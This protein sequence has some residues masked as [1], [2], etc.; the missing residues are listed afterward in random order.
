VDSNRVQFVRVRHTSLLE[1]L[2]CIKKRGSK[3]AY[4][5]DGVRTSEKKGATKQRRWPRFGKNKSE[6]DAVWIMKIFWMSIALVYSASM[7]VICIDWN[8]RFGRGVPDR[9]GIKDYSRTI[10]QHDF[11]T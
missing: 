1:L 11:S 6:A 8:G 9:F 4:E 5:R 2:L 7:G 3:H 10:H